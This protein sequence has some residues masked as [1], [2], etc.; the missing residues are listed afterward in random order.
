[1]HDHKE[2]QPEPCKV[3]AYPQLCSWQTPPATT[4]LFDPIYDQFTQIH[5]Q[6]LFSWLFFSQFS[7]LYSLPPSLS[8]SFLFFFNIFYWW[9]FLCPLQIDCPH[10]PLLWQVY[11]ISTGSIS[12]PCLLT[13]SFSIS[14][15][16]NDFTVEKPASIITQAEI[17]FSQCRKLQWQLS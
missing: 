16:S 6:I 4:L 1:M 2:Q 14:F 13:D 3:D 8:L 5:S 9:P 12:T 7:S 15:A 10:A 11:F 17:F